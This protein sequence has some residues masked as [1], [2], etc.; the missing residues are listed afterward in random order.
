VLFSSVRKR[1]TIGLLPGLIALLTLLGVG[2]FA[3]DMLVQA[4]RHLAE[5]GWELAITRSLQLH[6]QQAI[7]PIDNALQERGVNDEYGDF[8]A[9]ADRLDAMFIEAGTQYGETDE[10]LYFDRA[11]AGWNTIR[12]QADKLLFDSSRTLTSAEADMLQAELQTTAN[13]VWNE[14]EHLND[15]VLHEMQET[16]ASSQRAHDAASAL[17]IGSSLVALL[18]GILFLFL[19]A[20][21]ITRPLSALQVGA[22]RIG[23]G[24]LDMRLDIERQDEIGDLALEFNRMAEQLRDSIQHLEERVD[25]RTAQLWALNKAGQSV[26]GERRLDRVLQTIAD[27]ARSLGN[28]TFAAVLVPRAQNDGP[29]R[30]IV[31]QAVTEDPLPD[32]SPPSGRG[33]LGL[34]LQSEQPVRLVDLQGHP[35][36]DGVPAG[37]PSMNGFLGIPIRMHGATIGGLYLTN[38]QDDALFSQEDEDLL[39]MLAAYAGIAIE[40]ARLYE[41]L[42]HMNEALERRV[43][44]RTAEL[45]AV[46]AQR[47]ETAAD[48]RRVLNRNLQIQEEEQQRIAKGIHDGVSQWL[49][50]AMFELQAARVRLP[51]DQGEIG[52]HLKEAQ[53]VLKEVK[54]EMR[55]VIYDLHPPLLESNGLVTAMRNHIQELEAHSDMHVNFVIEGEP[56]RLK[57]PQELAIFRIGQESLTNVRKHADC[58]VAAVHLSFEADC[59]RLCVTDTGQG[60]TPSKQTRQGPA[61][62]GLLSMRE[63]ASAVGASLDLKSKPEG[64][65]VVNVRVPHSPEPHSLEPG[66]SNPEGSLLHV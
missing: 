7:I 59:V 6:L 49:M 37:H 9:L 53:R 10:R 62:L 13:V 39:A 36:A 1:L 22:H 35:S 60:F 15:K 57:R 46:S 11:L 32:L 45:E 63:R 50:G 20:N 4:N 5:A 38:K 3:T 30:F 66:Q 44:E 28:A 17:L 21:H 2:L 47:A 33:M 41:E 31:S 8:T 27:L 51:A 58:D 40:N 43:L 18:L 48:L 16:I 42:T 19:F 64:G 52:G 61:Q 23:A 55:R 54:E 14:L 12:S 25:E 56:R 34:L 29:P 24:E 26:V 65:T